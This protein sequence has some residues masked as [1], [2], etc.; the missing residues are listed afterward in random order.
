MGYSQINCGFIDLQKV[1]PT[2]QVELR[3]ASSKNFMG[4]KVKGYSFQRAYGTEGLAQALQKVQ[5]KLA[6][7]GLGLK[8]YDAYRPQRAVDDFISWAEQKEDT[9]QKEK[10]Y[11]HIDKKN[12]FNAGYI[13]KRS[14]HSRGS[15]VDLTLIKIE[16]PQKNEELDMGGTWDFFGERSH[17]NYSN[18]SDKQKANRKLL[19]SVMVSAGFSSYEK[20]WWHFTLKNEP[21]PNTY[22]D[23]IPE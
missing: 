5:S 10:Y 1:N 7:Q 9:L 8:I 16:G 11:P 15:T 18:I 2:L 19:R 17:F 4:R 20:E 23:F 6:Q 3:Y 14:G 22:F 12:L 13:A 21:Y